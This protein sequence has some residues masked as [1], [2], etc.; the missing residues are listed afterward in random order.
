MFGYLLPNC[1]SV[2]RLSILIWT[3]SFATDS[4]SLIDTP[5]GV[6]II[7]SGLNPANNPISTSCIET[8]SKPDPSLDINFN[9]EILVY[10]FAA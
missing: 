8:V 3:P 10:A 1:S 6:Y 4:S 5:F 9:I 2:S 7:S